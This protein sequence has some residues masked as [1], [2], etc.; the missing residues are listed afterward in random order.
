MSRPATLEHLRQLVTGGAARVGAKFTRPDDDWTTTFFVQTPRGLE[1]VGIDPAI[2][3]NDAAKDAV[4]QLL[5][6]QVVRVGAYRY[7]FLMSTWVV[8]PDTASE[9]Q[10]QAIQAGELRVRDVEGRSEQLT[11]VL[12]DAEEE[13]VWYA[14]I[15]RHEKLPPKLGRWQ[16]SDADAWGGRFVGLNEYL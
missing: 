7:A 16:R 4:G 11:L 3:S 6:E 10:L 13:Q 9:E 15:E 14:P 12:G 2:L 5:R 8:D 1:I